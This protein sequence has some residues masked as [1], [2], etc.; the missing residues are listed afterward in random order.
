MK[1]LLT[2]DLH[3]HSHFG[4][5]V[6]IDIGINYLKYISNYCLKNN[7]KYIFIL[8][9]MFHLSSK[10]DVEIYLPI[11][12]E[13]KK[14]KEKGINV[15]LIPGNHEVYSSDNKTI[16]DSL[17]Q[18]ATIHN[19]YAKETIDK[20]DFYYLPYR[21]KIEFSELKP[22]PKQKENSILL[23]HLDVAGFKMNSFV[24]SKGIKEISFFEQFKYCFLGHIHFHQHKNNIVYIGSPY[25]QNFGESDNKGFI[26]FDNE[27]NSWERF[28]YED[29]PKFRTIDV[30]ESLNEDLSNTFVR[31]I[32]KKKIDN[33]SKLREILYDRGA[34]DI[35]QDFKIEENI[36]Q[37][38]EIKF[39]EDKTLVGM[40][41]SFISQD[42]TKLN[43]EKL[44]ITLDR[45][46]E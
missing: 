30:E 10:I 7:I 24:I 26:V 13:F 19:T 8:G 2:A 21:R 4:N 5:P 37:M 16:L 6:F 42:E 41:R 15:I 20:T 3:I 45:I 17:D 40:V 31:L 43:K 44:L 46:V 35:T 22:L 36:S 39:D 29:A 1:F 27:K 33:L 14:I 23:S 18:F 34:L 9:D 25:Q 12:E 11:F 32:I 28:I 38:N